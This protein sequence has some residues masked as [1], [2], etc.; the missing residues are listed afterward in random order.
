MYYVDEA[1]AHAEP[2][3]TACPLA[4]NQSGV[5]IP[6]DMLGSQRP[7]GVSQ[8]KCPARFYKNAT[9]DGGCVPC[10]VAEDEAGALVPLPATTPGITAL[11]DCRCPVTFFLHV[12]AARCMQCP[13]ALNKSAATEVYVPLPARATPIARLEDCACPRGFFLNVSESTCEMCPQARTPDGALVPMPVAAS[14]SDS[15]SI[16]GCKCPLGFFLDVHARVCVQCPHAFAHT[17]AE[18][19][20]PPHTE[21]KTSAAQ[22]LCPHGFFKNASGCHHCPPAILANGTVVPLPLD[23]IAAVIAEARECRCPAGFYM[24][25]DACVEC[26][27]A[28]DADGVHVPLPPTPA[29]MTAVAQCRCP[30]GF[31]EADAQCT[32]CPRAFDAEAQAFVAVPLQA[33]LPDIERLDQCVCPAGFYRKQAACEQCPRARKQHA[34]GGEVVLPAPATAVGMTSVSECKCPAGFYLDLTT[35]IC[36]HCPRAEFQDIVYPLT[37]PAGISRAVHCGCP[38]GFYWTGTGCGACEPGFYCDG[39][40]ARAACGESQVSPALAKTRAACTCA[41]GF[42]VDPADAT[43]CVTCLNCAQTRVVRVEVP[44]LELEATGDKSAEAIVQAFA[45]QAQVPRPA[46]AVTD[47]GCRFTYRKKVTARTLAGTWKNTHTAKLEQELVADTAA[48]TARVT[49]TNPVLVLDYDTLNDNQRFGVQQFREAVELM[50]ASRRR[51]LEHGGAHATQSLLIDLT[52]IGSDL[53][54]QQLADKYLQV[55][56]IN[57]TIAFNVTL[58]AEELVDTAGF[59]QNVQT[60]FDEL[61]GSAYQVL[62]P[63]ETAAPIVAPATPVVLAFAIVDT[64][65]ASDANVLAVG[66]QGGEF[67]QALQR[68]AGAES[69]TVVLQVA[70][71]VETKQRDVRI[72]Q[73][74]RFECALGSFADPLRS[75]ACVCA[76]ETECVPPAPSATTGCVAGRKRQCLPVQRRSHSRMRTLLFVLAGLCG[77]LVLIAVALECVLARRRRRWRAWPFARYHVVATGA[78]AFAQAQADAFAQAE[79][80]AANLV[81]ET[82]VGACPD[83]AC[84]C[85]HPMCASR[86][87]VDLQLPVYE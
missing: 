31:Y 55:D 38:A 46:V 14:A 44:A 8:C 48:P 32:Q 35:D 17:G 69:P 12:A 59:K 34:D 68:V 11:S 82:H 43:R 19:A 21:Y 75:M 18:V 39:S 23:L 20:L 24:H 26:P 9:G 80:E 16:A 37:G 66:V 2:R 5:E 51:L 53:K 29:G 73:P 81:H 45:M 33:L 4:V 7:R 84:R 52:G 36:A 28:K 79:A 63:V 74:A 42:T 61:M 25:A 64:D 86:N 76:P 1:H 27:V 87:V 22:C 30:R 49:C 72:E 57:V 56:G 47:L 62:T 3:C 70:L 10:P 77:A 71:T 58:E 78:D 65:G 67:Q 40:G 41:T 15:Q 83:P 54:L 60:N 85:F 6:L 13:L 50:R